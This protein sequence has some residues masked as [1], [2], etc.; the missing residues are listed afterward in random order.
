MHVHVQICGTVDK[1]TGWYFDAILLKLFTL[2][3]LY[4]G[5]L[6]V[7]VRETGKS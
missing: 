2:Y 6:S 4:H 1:V 3:W 5:V 7:N